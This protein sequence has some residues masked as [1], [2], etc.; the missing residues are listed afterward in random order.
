M[1]H[2]PPIAAEAEK[3]GAPVVAMPVAQPVTKGEKKQEET[4]ID[5]KMSVSSTMSN[6]HGQT[7]NKQTQH[8]RRRTVSDT[9]KLSEKKMHCHHDIAMLSP[10]C[11]FIM[12]LAFMD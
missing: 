10:I 4:E 5:A 2:A 1:S 8:L 9:H 3:G 6:T 7:K 12:H 11:M